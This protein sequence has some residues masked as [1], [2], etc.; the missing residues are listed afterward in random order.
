MGPRLRGGPSPCSCSSP[1]SRPGPGP[2]TPRAWSAR[3]CWRWSGDGAAQRPFSAAQQTPSPQHDGLCRDS[4]H[5]EPLAP[6]HPGPSGAGSASWA[7]KLRS[8]PAQVHLGQCQSQP[9]TAWSPGCLLPTAARALPPRSPFLTSCQPLQPGVLFLFVF[10]SPHQPTLG[11]S[12][13]FMVWAA[14]LLCPQRP[15]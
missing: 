1:F 7:P 12:Q 11:S 14:A 3:R 6:C 4:S 13:S 5:L 9:P 8:P 15:C 2:R 10:T